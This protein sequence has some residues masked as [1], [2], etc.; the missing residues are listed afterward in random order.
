M[1]KRRRGSKEKRQGRVNGS[2]PNREM[3]AN[4]LRHCDG[5]CYEAA[6]MFGVPFYVFNHW[7]NAFGLHWANA[8]G[9]LDESLEIEMSDLTVA[10][11]EFMS[12]KRSRA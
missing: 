7:A 2:M 3:I 1:C 8:F 4:A 10:V 6:D 9:L 12:G 5:D 11:D